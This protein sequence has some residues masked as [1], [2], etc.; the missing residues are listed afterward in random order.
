MDV[1]PTDRIHPKKDESECE[2]ATQLYVDPEGRI[3][4]GACIPACWSDS[5]FVAEEPPE[6]KEAFSGKERRLFR[7]AGLRFGALRS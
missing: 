4:C 5:I 7:E 6:D 2:A 1:C 3:A